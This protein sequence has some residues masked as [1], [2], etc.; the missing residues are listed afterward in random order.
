MGRISP[1]RDRP[2]AEHLMI[3]FEQSKGKAMHGTTINRALITKEYIHTGKAVMDNMKWL[4]KQGKIVKIGRGVYGMP[5]V[6]ED[7][8]AYIE[9]PDISKIVELGKL[10]PNGA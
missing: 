8:T 1:K 9:D 5:I 6:R 2:T 10:K 4:I 3:I 7:G